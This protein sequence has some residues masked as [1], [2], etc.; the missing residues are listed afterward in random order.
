VGCGKK[1][2]VMVRKKLY[3]VSSVTLPPIPQAKTRTVKEL[4][5]DVNY[6]INSVLSR[7]II[8]ASFSQEA[9]SVFLKSQ[10][11]RQPAQDF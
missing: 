3:S 9:E 4:L 7:Y 8:R 11:F 2:I 5:E 1:I 6:E 10:L